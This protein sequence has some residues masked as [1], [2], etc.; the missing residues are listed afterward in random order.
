M[1]DTGAR[2]KASETPYW[3][4]DLRRL[5]RTSEDRTGVLR[6]D[7]EAQEPRDE[8]MP[9]EPVRP[10]EVPAKAPPSRPTPRR[11]STPMEPLIVTPREHT[12][13][14]ISVEDHEDQTLNE[15]F[16]SM[17]ILNPNEARDTS[18]L[19]I[20]AEG[21]RQPNSRSYTDT[22]KR[23]NSRLTIPEKEEPKQFSA[24]LDQILEAYEAG[25]KA[26]GSRSA[27]RSS[28]R[29]SSMNSK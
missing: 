13:L 24:A 15:G 16:K 14:Y 11:S 1:Y 29:A 23:T 17:S 3:T 27:S 8:R 12:G 6:P 22:L 18:S 26:A 21:L 9:P 25:K 2:P 28:S 7:M 20:R 19:N 5:F 10:R 4:D